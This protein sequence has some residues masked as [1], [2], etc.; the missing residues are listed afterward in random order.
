MT[1]DATRCPYYEA[2]SQNVKSRWHCVIARNMMYQHMDDHHLRLPNNKEDCLVC[3]VVVV[4][5]IKICLLCLKS[6]NTWTDGLLPE[7]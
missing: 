1:N 4:W 5:I 2:Q 3:C 6:K 7:S